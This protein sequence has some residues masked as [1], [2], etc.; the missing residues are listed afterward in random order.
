MEEKD[1]KLEKGFNEVVLTLSDITLM[2]ETIE[3]RLHGLKLIPRRGPAEEMLIDQLKHA[4]NGLE[5][6]IIKSE[7]KNIVNTLKEI[8]NGRERKHK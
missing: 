3:M 2:Y 1:T 4:Q 6:I 7:R 8:Q 5:Q